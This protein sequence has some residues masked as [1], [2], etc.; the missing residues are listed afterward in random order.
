MTG[1]TVGQ[2]RVQPVGLIWKPWKFALS[3]RTPAC[4]EMAAHET[5]P[6]VMRLP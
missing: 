5:F 1:P 6:S 2:N 4:L 3:Q